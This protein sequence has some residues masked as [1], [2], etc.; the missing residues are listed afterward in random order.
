MGNR[1]LAVKT[2]N[3]PHIL[4][5]QNA[6]GDWQAYDTVCGQIQG[7]R[8]WYCCKEHMEQRIQPDLTVIYVKHA[9]DVIM[10]D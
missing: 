9:E 8:V 4:F 3:K 5:E 1:K 10:N 6:A 2:C 7:N